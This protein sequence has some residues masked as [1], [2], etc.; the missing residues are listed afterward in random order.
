[1]H[2]TSIV[3]EM[4]SLEKASRNRKKPNRAN[5]PILYDN[6]GKRAN[7]ALC[8]DVAGISKFKSIK[9]MRNNG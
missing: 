6:A 4:H 9:Y 5:K 8:Y 2:N 1:M 3:H 7:A